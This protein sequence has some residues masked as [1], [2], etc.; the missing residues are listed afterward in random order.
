MTA[1]S[2]SEV[3]APGL[4]SRSTSPSL[5]A[6]LALFEGSYLISGLAW[7]SRSAPTPTLA[8]H[9]ADCLV[10]MERLSVAPDDQCVRGRGDQEERQH[11]IRSGTCHESD[12][13]SAGTKARHGDR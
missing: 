7:T 2:A 4:A 5:R 10:E 13:D 11:H 9:S 6:S 1:A 3:G 8:R 12:D